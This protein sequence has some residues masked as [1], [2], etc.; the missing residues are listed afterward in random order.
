MGLFFDVKSVIQV[1]LKLQI[2]NYELREKSSI[3]YSVRC[4]VYYEV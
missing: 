3:L 2:I 4:P 1:I